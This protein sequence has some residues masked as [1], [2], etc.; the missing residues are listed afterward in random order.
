MSSDRIYIF[1]VALFFML[2]SLVASYCWSLFRV[3]LIPT[4]TKCLPW[5]TEEVYF[6]LDSM[7]Y[8]YFADLTICQDVS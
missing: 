7:V 8:L 3:F 5:V 4:R 2:T 1:E 6:K